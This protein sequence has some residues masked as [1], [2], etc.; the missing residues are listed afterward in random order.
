M[1][2]PAFLITIDT[3]GDDIWGRHATVTTEN[4]RYLPRFQDLCRKHGFKP[5]YLTNYEM[6]VD[7]RYQ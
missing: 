2:S 4:A 5:T 7:S 1:E 6:A 3:E